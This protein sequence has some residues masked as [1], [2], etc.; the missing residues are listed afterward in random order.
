MMIL[1]KRQLD[2]ESARIKLKDYDMNHDGSVTW[3]EYTSRVYGY[4]SEELEQLAK[5]SSNETQAFLRVSPGT[6]Q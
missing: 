5:D 4:T 3:A 2:M 1:F 6:F